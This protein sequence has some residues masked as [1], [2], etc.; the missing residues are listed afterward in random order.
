MEKC[1]F[2]THLNC[3]AE[4]KTLLARGGGLTQEAIQDKQ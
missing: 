3:S 4:S 2:Q 1:P